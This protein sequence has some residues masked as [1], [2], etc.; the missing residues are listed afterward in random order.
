M[1]EGHLY[2]T[3]MKGHKPH[4]SRCILWPPV[5]ASG[6]VGFTQGAARAL[7][8]STPPSERGTSNW[9]AVLVGLVALSQ[10]SVKHCR[11]HSLKRPGTAPKLALQQVMHGWTE[12][13]T[14]QMPLE[15]AAT[16]GQQKSNQLEGVKL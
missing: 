1:A 2:P 6:V 11:A 4:I 3:I 13:S 14:G 10:P 8:S 15:G 5:S 12:Q 9:P 7:G 16:P